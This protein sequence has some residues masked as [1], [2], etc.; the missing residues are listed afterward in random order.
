MKRLVVLL[1]ILLIGISLLPAQESDLQTIL[2]AGF[3]NQ[4]EEVDEKYNEVITKSLIVLL[5][6]VPGVQVVEF[7]DVAE[8]T[9]ENGLWSL[10]EHDPEIL[11]VMGLTMG[12][13]KVVVGEFNIDH[14]EEVITGSYYVYSMVTGEL[15]MTRSFEGDAGID[16]LDSIDEVTKKVSF[17]L[18]G[19]EIALGNVAISIQEEEKAYNVY[20]NSQLQGTATSSDVYEDTVIADTDVEVSLR[21]V[22]TNNLGEEVEMEVYRETVNIPEDETFHID[23]SASGMILVKAVDLPGANVYV[24]GEL[25]GQADENGDYTIVNIPAGESQKIVIEYD[26]KEIDTVTKSVSEGESVVVVMG[27]GGDKFIIG[28][29]ILDGGGLSA[30]AFVGFK[31]T[32]NLSMTV[33][34]GVVYMNLNDTNGNI[35]ENVFVPVADISVGYNF[36]NLD[37]IGMKLGLS[38]GGFFHFPA[39]QTVFSL[40]ARAHV[41]WMFMFVQAGVRYSFSEALTDSTGEIIPNLK[42]ILCAGVKFNF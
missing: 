10:E 7:D 40:T 5:S 42:P 41:E 21:L 30:M 29:K 36:L 16:L 35:T 6:K 27:T 3:I 4:G 28:G 14:E 26:G 9:A 18:L 37:A 11:E 15:L 24:N 32:P 34:G 22:E 12:A 23:Y 39:G 17:A 38:L 2:I 19:R 13:K 20:I 33:G 25:V 31:F 1:S 8:A